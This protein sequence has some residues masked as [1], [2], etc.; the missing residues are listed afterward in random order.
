MNIIMFELQKWHRLKLLD[1]KSLPNKGAGG[2]YKKFCKT[3]T[4]EA[5]YL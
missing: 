5:T 4:A 1:D 3:H 2:R